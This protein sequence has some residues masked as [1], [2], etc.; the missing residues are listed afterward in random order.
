MHFLVNYILKKPI[1]LA[2]LLLQAASLL[3]GAT[4]Y[5]NL[6]TYL[7][8]T[9]SQERLSQ[10][11]HDGIFSEKMVS[12][13]V[14]L[15][16]HALTVSKNAYEKFI[17]S[18]QNPV[19]G[20]K[21]SIEKTQQKCERIQDIIVLMQK[22]RANTSDTLKAKATEQILALQTYKIAEELTDKD[23]QTSEKKGKETVLNKENGQHLLET[24]NKLKEK[25][26]KA[27]QNLVEIH[28][29]ETDLQK[30]IQDFG[31]LN[32]SCT[33]KSPTTKGANNK[34]QPNLATLL[35]ENIEGIYDH[36]NE[37]EV[38][39][40]IAKSHPILCLGLNIILRIPK[41]EDTRIIINKIRSCCLFSAETPQ[42]AEIGQE[43][44][45]VTD[46][47]LVECKRINRNIEKYKTNLKRQQLFT[48]LIQNYVHSWTFDQNFSRERVIQLIQGKKVYCCITYKQPIMAIQNNS[49]DEFEKML[50]QSSSRAESR[51]TGETII[52]S[53]GI[54]I[55]NGDAYICPLDISNCSQ[56]LREPLAK[57]AISALVQ[58]KKDALI[59][60]DRPLILHITM[61][62]EQAPLL[63]KILEFA[64]FIAPKIRERR[65]SAPEISR[66]T[67]TLNQQAGT[68][69]LPS[70]KQQRTDTPTS[71]LG[72]LRSP[73]YVMS[74]QTRPA[75]PIIAFDNTPPTTAL[76]PTPEKTPPRK[77]VSLLHDT[78]QTDEKKSAA[79]CAKKL[80]L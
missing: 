73:A 68:P 52:L 56:D 16:A 18:L 45:I 55:D 66:A 54:G 43:F 35:S 12:Q 39:L 30:T 26:R 9:F 22:S 61:K 2:I 53:Q 31:L 28:P 76:K 65:N 41:N 10:L 79:S 34:N 25:A 38:A 20:V 24:I 4:S 33:L 80:P 49:V 13:L 51:S 71:P 70:S 23:F 27:L 21:E 62:D 11:Q 64:G 17:A 57:S 78:T 1:L 60:S 37:L 15:K 3:H 5:E 6:A 32:K 77:T 75:S 29:L 7:E 36:L 14:N 63:K 46:V 59:H 67:P 69:S 47:D 40:G 74:I 8:E 42:Y 44:D 72:I 48:Q 58:A 19:P 50:S